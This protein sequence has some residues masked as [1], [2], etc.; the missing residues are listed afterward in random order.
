MNNQE[1]FMQNALGCLNYKS[2]QNL[3]EELYL[4]AIIDSYQRIDK[5]VDLEN[6]IRDRFVFDLERKNHLTQDLVQ[7]GILQ[8][9]FERTHFVSETEKRRTD[10]VFFI[11]GFGNFTCECKRLFRQDSKNNEYIDEG[12]KR[13]IELKYSKNNQYSAMLGFVVDGEIDK[14]KTFLLKKC[15]ANNYIKNE[16]TEQE[17]FDWMNSFKTAHQRSDYTEIKMYHLLFSFDH[18]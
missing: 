6:V 2:E 13:F 17:Y 18:N 3:Y 1:R 9:D 5:S 14:I 15:E 11:S 12:L 16:F 7:K 4:K 10:I 8:L